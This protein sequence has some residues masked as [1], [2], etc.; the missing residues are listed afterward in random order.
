MF[1]SGQVTA[2]GQPLTNTI[3]E[4]QPAGT[5]IPWLRTNVPTQLFLWHHRGAALVVHAL[6][7]DGSYSRQVL[8][9][10]LRHPEAHFQLAMPFMTWV[11]TEVLSETEYVL[12]SGSAVP[13]FN[14]L[15]YDVAD[16]TRLLA[17]FPKHEAVIME[18]YSK[19]DQNEVA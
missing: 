5:R 9:D 3:L 15:D 11:S 17:E 12:M 14:R 1:T 4:L 19:L 18:V 2:A 7:P 8:G 6:L 13:S 16:P 10:P